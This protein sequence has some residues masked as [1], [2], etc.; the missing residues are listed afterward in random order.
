MKAHKRMIEL[1]FRLG[2]Q[3]ISKIK[4]WCVFCIVGLDFLL[5]SHGFDKQKR[6]RLE[7]ALHS[8]D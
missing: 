4:T 6:E 8:G 5:F 3:A 7:V 2:E 1:T